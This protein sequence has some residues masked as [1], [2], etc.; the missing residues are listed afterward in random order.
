MED[1]L[2]DLG[3]DEYWENF[4]QS[5]YTEPRML[6]DIK[7]MNKETLKNDFNI[8]KPGHLDKLYKAL[9]KVQYPTECKYELT[10]KI[11][12]S[13]PWK[14]QIS[15]SSNFLFFHP[16]RPEMIFMTVA[17]PCHR[18]YHYHAAAIFRDLQGGWYARHL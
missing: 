1:W 6:E 7:F 13:L 9:Q 16:W 8:F 15:T 2:V 11:L 4:K 5:G 12:S 10:R 18:P 14:F 17:Q 3:L